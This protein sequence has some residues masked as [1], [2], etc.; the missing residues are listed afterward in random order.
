MKKIIYTFA[1]IALSVSIVSC[2][3]EEA[4]NVSPAATTSLFTWTSDNGTTTI[5]ADSAYYDSRYKTIKAFKG[6]MAQFVEIN[7][8]NDTVGTYTLGSANAVS[9]L[10]GTAL[11]VAN[12]G[13]VNISAKSSTKISGAFASTSTSGTI[14]VLN[15]TF[16]NISVR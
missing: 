6:G 11:Y 3:E 10:N 1:F 14:T 16:A 8:S 9:Y 7:L 13:A 15:G 12:A 5:T 2:S 4:N